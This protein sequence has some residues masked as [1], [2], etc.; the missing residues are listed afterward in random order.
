MICDTIGRNL[1]RGHNYGPGF[2]LRLY[3]TVLFDSYTF[4]KKEKSSD[5]N[6]AEEK[7]KKVSQYRTIISECR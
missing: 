5:W 6:V 2:E 7:K 3:E 4:D 1:P